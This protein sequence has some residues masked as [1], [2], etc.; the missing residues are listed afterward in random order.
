M[1]AKDERQMLKSIHEE[2]KRWDPLIDLTDNEQL[3]KLHFTFTWLLSI[4]LFKLQDIIN[5]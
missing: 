2:A 5:L 1:W 3:I 4:C